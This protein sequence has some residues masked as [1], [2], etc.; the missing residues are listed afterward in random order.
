[1]MSKISE[2]EI[3]VKITEQKR[4]NLSLTTSMVSTSERELQYERGHGLSMI[5][6]IRS[7]GSGRNLRTCL[8][9]VSFRLG[10]PKFRNSLSDSSE[11]DE[12]EA[13]SFDNLN[14]EY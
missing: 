4:M 10:C 7:P 9:L 5:M 3:L 12:T 13:N 2:F 1:M 6:I 11:N 14:V 8:C